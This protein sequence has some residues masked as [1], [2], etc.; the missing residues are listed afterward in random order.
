[1]HSKPRNLHSQQG[2]VARRY[3]LSILAVACAGFT[4]C[5]FLPTLSAQD[6][7]GRVRDGQNGF[8]FVPPPGWEA[9]S[10]RTDPA[11]RFLYLGPTYRSFRANVN[12]VVETDTGESFAEIAQQIK[13]MYPRLFSALKLVEESPLEINGK[14]SYYISFTHRSRGH[15]LKQAQF[16][17]RGGNGKVYILTFA[18][19]ESAFEELGPAIVQSALSIKT[20]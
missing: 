16:I 1:M 15:T 7:V 12:L 5:G 4:V 8:S 9:S 2:T 3:Y 10:L 11:V 18:A 19:M 17:V 6:V 20:E 13:D 14:K